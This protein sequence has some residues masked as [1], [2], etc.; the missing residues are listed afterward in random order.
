MSNVLLLIFVP[1]LALGG[2]ASVA[3]LLDRR[4]KKS[5]LISLK[6]PEPGP[7]SRVLLWIARILVAFMILSIVGAFAF[8]LLALALI[9]AGCL[10]LYII[11]GL[12][13]RSVRL[14]G[15]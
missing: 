2:L 5:H 9:A 7:L 1:M 6:L 12:I 4:A 8:R 10:A 13:Y 3:Y 11:D 15:K 14:T